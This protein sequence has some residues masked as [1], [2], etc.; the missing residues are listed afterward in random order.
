MGPQSD[1]SGK[2][3]SGTSQVRACIPY[4][5]WHSKRTQ[6]HRR[7]LFFLVSV[8][9]SLF[10]HPISSH[11]MPFCYLHLSYNSDLRVRQ[12]RSNT[13]TVSQASVRIWVPRG[14][15]ENQQD[16]RLVEFNSQM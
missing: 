10:N 14:R 13:Q 15:L 11:R 7:G 1:T 8:C 5:L 12:E 6:V 9:P 2:G 16:S 4:S 3:A